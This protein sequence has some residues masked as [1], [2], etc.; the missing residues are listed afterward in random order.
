MA[1]KQYKKA[2]DLIAKTTKYPALIGATMKV[3]EKKQKM[4]NRMKDTSI[5][6]DALEVKCDSLST[7]DHINGR[8]S[9]CNRR[10][11]QR[12]T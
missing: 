2:L 8:L 10:R 1:L 12:E 5:D 6:E 3:G 7:T 11:G 4:K 9:G